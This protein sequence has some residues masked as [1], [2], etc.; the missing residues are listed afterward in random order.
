MKHS[1]EGLSVRVS[2]I[3]L[4]CVLAVPQALIGQSGDIR[5]Q[6]IE[7]DAAVNNVRGRA[8]AEPVVQV[9]D[10]SGNPIPNAA[11]TFRAPTEGPSVTFFGASHATTI[12]T[13]ENGRAAATGMLPNTYSG[14]FLI[15]VEAEAGSRQAATTIAQTNA[16]EPPLEKRKQKWGWKIWTLVGAGVAAGVAAGV[17]NGRSSA[18]TTPPGPGPAPAGP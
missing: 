11:V 10:G 17:L 8:T 7:G 1:R 6:V 18:Q 3:T 13:D 4:A 5:I 15:A 9:T 14:E 2:A 12:S 16:Y